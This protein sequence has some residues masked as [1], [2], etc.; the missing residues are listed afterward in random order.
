MRNAAAADRQLKIAMFESIRQ[1]LMGEGF[2]LQAPKHRFIRRRDGITYI[3]QLVC[4]E[5]RPGWRIQPDVAVRIDRVE[6]IFHRTSGFEPRYQK[7]TP[8]VG[9]AIGNI[10]QGDNRACEFLLESDSDI[11]SVSQESVRVFREFAVPYFNRFSSLSEIDAE[12]NDAPTERT[13]HRVAPWLRCAPGLIVAKLTGRPNYDQLVDIYGDVM[14]RSDEGFY[15]KRFEALVKSLES[16][17]LES[18][19]RRQT[20]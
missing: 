9:G 17:E 3:F 1:Q 20:H 11:A 8:T 18:T 15:L 12:L 14:R 2:I 5:A 19:S 13:P 7:D 16:V 10:M 4:L 6:E